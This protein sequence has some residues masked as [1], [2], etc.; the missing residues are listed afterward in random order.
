MPSL[1]T[2]EEI[3]L[4]HELWEEFTK[5]VYVYTIPPIDWFPM[6][7]HVWQWIKD[8]PEN[9]E[10]IY[11]KLQEARLGIVVFLSRPRH[12]PSA[13]FTYNFTTVLLAGFAH[14][15]RVSC[16]PEISSVTFS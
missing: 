3:Y 14:R 5:G 15:T 1:I 4:P 13:A 16:H 7:T 11:G 9:D 8:A 12:S 6:E 10:D 2:R